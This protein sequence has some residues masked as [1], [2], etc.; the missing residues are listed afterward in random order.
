MVPGGERGAT[1]NG[2][3]VA[4]ID[5]PKSTET[6]S[7]SVPTWLVQ[8]VD[9]YVENGA[10]MSRSSFIVRSVRKYLL[11]K[12]DSPKLWKSIYNGKI[13]GSCEDL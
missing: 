10:D 5:L 3:T 8:L 7:I 4:R 13:E 1:L 6:I 11:L 9:E 12:H 2:K